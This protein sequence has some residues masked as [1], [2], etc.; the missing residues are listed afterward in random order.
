MHVVHHIYNTQ[1]EMRC[2]GEQTHIRGERLGSVGVGVD[3]IISN[4]I[5]MGTGGVSGNNHPTHCIIMSVL[6]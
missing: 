6:S 4:G 5:L 1:R 2:I 3:G